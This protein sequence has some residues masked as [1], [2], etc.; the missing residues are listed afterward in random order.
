[1]CKN[2]V[3]AGAADKMELQVAYAIGS[4]HPVSLCV[5]TH[6]TGHIK[7]KYILDIIRGFFDFRPGAIIRTLGLEAP[8]YAATT[9][10]GHFGK[11]DLPWEQ[12][13]KASDI[14]AYIRTLPTA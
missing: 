11:R 13:D 4:A 8:I 1:M 7:D 2:L 14:M 12:T 6:G 5:N 9:N 3:A 10:Y